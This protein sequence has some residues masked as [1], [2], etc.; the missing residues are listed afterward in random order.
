[1]RPYFTERTPWEQARL[2]RQSR[3]IEQITASMADLRA[4][5]AGYLADVLQSVGSQFGG[6]V[7]NALPGL[8]WHQWGQAVDC[9]WLLGRRAEWSSRKLVDGQNGYRVYAEIARDQGLMAGGYW[10]RLKDWPHVQKSS[11]GSPRSAGKSLEE[12]ATTM[13]ARFGDSET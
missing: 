11:F 12:I 9:F 6:P 8:S 10:R 4:E 2:W 1:M 7:T 13:Q 5:N 3:S